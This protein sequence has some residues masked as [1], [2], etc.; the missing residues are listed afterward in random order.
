MSIASR[1]L[2]RLWRLPAS[3]TR[4]IIEYRDLRVPV[5]GGIELLMD[6]YH[7][8]SGE[9]LPVVLIRSPYGL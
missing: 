4:D 2:G 1:I 6:R 8:R 3:I 5:S 7:P 9:N